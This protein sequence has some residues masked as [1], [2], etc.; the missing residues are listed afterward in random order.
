MIKTLATASFA[1]LLLAGTA[2]AAET[3][4]AVSNYDAAT[5]ML[6]LDTGETYVLAEGVDPGDIAAGA[7]VT[8]THEDGSTDATAVT[9][10]E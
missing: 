2:Y 9:V 3:E 7:D 8:V 1:A 5:R 6:T 10:N 4:G